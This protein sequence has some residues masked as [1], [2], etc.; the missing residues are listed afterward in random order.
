MLF[1]LKVFVAIFISLSVNIL[2]GS[3]PPCDIEE[4]CPFSN[5]PPFFVNNFSF[6]LIDLLFRI[7][8]YIHSIT[9]ATPNKTMPKPTF[10]IQISVE[11]YTKII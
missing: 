3:I 9:M 11:F 4:S 2:I 6:I 1:A 8:M 7:I 5:N 10:E